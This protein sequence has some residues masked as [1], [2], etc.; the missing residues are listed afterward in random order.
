MSEKHYAEVV[1]SENT[2][3]A[4][5]GRLLTLL[6]CVLA[7][8]A[9][10][11][12]ILNVKLGTE[13]RSEPQALEINEAF[14]ASWDSDAVRLLESWV[15]TERTTRWFLREFIKAL[16]ER[17]KEDDGNEKERLRFLGFGSAPSLEARIVRDYLNAHPAEDKTATYVELPSDD[18]VITRQGQNK[19]TVAWVE[20]EYEKA[21]GTFRS[22]TTYDGVFELGCYSEGLER[23]LKY[24]P[25]GLYV[26]YYDFDIRKE[27]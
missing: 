21:T 12:L 11:L 22:K 19:W 9:I 6:L 1:R 18:I 20:R 8:M 16:R 24:D 2:A 14:K 3:A 15:P 4:R 25:A 27:R 10:L 5:K 26:T 17:P 23:D 13:V 7:V